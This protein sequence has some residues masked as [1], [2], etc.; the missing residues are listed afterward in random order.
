MVSQTAA[1]LNERDV[2]ERSSGA[3][4][5]LRLSGSFDNPF[6]DAPRPRLGTAGVRH[7]LFRDHGFDACFR[8]VLDPAEVWVGAGSHDRAFHR[9]GSGAAW[10][11]VRSDELLVMALETASERPTRAL[12]SD[13]R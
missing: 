8:G 4:C 6:S 3:R 2:P 11:Y 1:S 5:R 12:S 13:S 10:C 7:R 9:L